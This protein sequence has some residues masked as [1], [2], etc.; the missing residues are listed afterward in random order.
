[1]GPPGA[2]HTDARYRQS[3]EGPI[4]ANAG[5]PYLEGR[6]VL[7]TG[8]TSGIG[9][10]VAT[11]LAR[12]TARARGQAVREELVRDT[13]NEAVEVV[14]ADLSLQADVRRAA[15]EFRARHDRLHVLVN[16]A[17]AVYGKRRLTADGIERTWALNHL[18]PFLLTELLSGTLARGAPARVVTVS[19]D[20]ARQG[21][22]DLADLQGARRRFRP[23]AV[24][25]ATKLANI[26]FTFE[27][28]R[29]RQGDGVTAT[30]M[31][32]GLV[33]TRWGRDLPPAFRAGVHVAHLVARSPDKGAETVVYL[34]ASPAVEG[35]SGLFYYDRRP[36][37]APPAAYD[38]E[39]A[40]ELWRRSAALTGLVTS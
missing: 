16:D 13:G 36:V 32:P 17:G 4:A 20:A 7:V 39:L 34:A 9:K 19:S 14:V 10:A 37:N 11:R 2:G 31:H 23:M 1:M 33:R 21:V 40:A 30:C 18:A 26:L 24:Y 27:L 6:V 25:G 38:Q 22:I 5:S 29:R 8:A 28:A 3:A 15:A 35:V 12:S